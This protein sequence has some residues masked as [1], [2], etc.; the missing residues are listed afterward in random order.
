MH[1]HELE[2]LIAKATPAPW[3]PD[4]AKLDGEWHWAAVGPITAAPAG[5][6]L[7]QLDKDFQAQLGNDALLIATLRNIAP[8]ML[9]M[10]KAIQILGLRF[11]ECMAADGTPEEEPTAQALHFATVDLADA[12]HVL[13][14][15]LQAIEA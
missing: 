2:E 14:A 15:K 10:W 6:Y 4:F 9:R 3:A 8:E 5:V 11:N 12:Q 7:N 1:L 13:N